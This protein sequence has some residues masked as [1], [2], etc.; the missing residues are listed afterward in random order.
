MKRY[1]VGALV[2]SLPTAVMAQAIPAS[3]YLI[4]A[5]ASDLFERQSGTVMSSSRNPKVRSFATM[6]VRDHGQSTAE[7]KAAA[8]AAHLAP[9]APRLDTMQARNLTALR[10]ARGEAR[11]RLYIEQQKAA[12]QDALALQQGYAT[13]G[14]VAP[15]RRVAGKIVPVV[16]HH[17][18]MLSSM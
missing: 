8:R 7:V 13:D 9:K 2:L 5:G 16:Q 18:E 12:H 3:T 10:N 6:M 14:R 15:L 4:K 17:I 1:L 11:D